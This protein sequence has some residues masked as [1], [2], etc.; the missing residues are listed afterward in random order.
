MAEENKRALKDGLK[1]GALASLAVTG[2]IAAAR[3]RET[4]DAWGAINDVS[5]ILLGEERSDRRGFDVQTTSLGL[6]LN[7]ASIVSWSVLYRRL[8]GKPQFPNSPLTAAGAVAAIYFIDYA[9][10]PRRLAPGFERRLSR[11]SVYMIYAVLALTFTL[12]NHPTD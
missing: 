2:A 12:V 6:L 8:F 9:V 7:A 5:H 3:A 4:G 1:L 10:F 11:Q